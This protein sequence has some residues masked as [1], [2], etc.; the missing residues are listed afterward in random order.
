[1]L[2][3][4]EMRDQ[5]HKNAKDKGWWDDDLMPPNPETLIPEKICL[6]HSELSEA[7]ECYRDPE[8]KANELWVASS[9]KIEGLPAELADVIIRIGDYCGYF[10][11]DIE[12][13]VRQ[14]MAY[15][16]TRS[17]RHGGKRA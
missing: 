5:A 14:K 2:G 7:L 1:M 10:G 3:L 16:A 8:H 11:I 9:G 13:T 12:D 6:M 4:N 17:H 15:N